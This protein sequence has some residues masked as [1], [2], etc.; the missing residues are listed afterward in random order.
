MKLKDLGR[1]SYAAVA[2]WARDYERAQELLAEFI[3]QSGLSGRD[4]YLRKVLRRPRKDEDL[5]AP[6]DTD[7]TLD[8]IFTIGPM[9]I[10]ANNILEKLRDV[11]KVDVKK[12]R[13]FTYNLW[14]TGLLVFEVRGYLSDYPPRKLDLKSATERLDRYLSKDY[15]VPERMAK[16]DRN[17]DE[18]TGDF[19]RV[20]RF[21]SEAEEICADFYVDE[22][23]HVYLEA[24][25]SRRA[26][27]DHL[28]R[29]IFGIL[30]GA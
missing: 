3:E 13:H 14:E 9:I 4:D 2:L 5:G 24:R 20:R 17:L 8:E 12:S 23:A 30:D 16:D 1:Y 25:A 18:S 28:A 26:S 21:M 15:R 11:K 29:D 6:S 27:V 19:S 7:S 10:R 22:D